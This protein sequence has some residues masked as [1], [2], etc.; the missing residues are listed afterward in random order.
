MS[1]QFQASS[2]QCAKT[3]RE[4]LP[5]ETIYSVLYERDGQWIREDIAADAWTGPSNQAFSFWQT[6]VTDQSKTAKPALNL[7]LVWD[8]FER[9]ESS[10][11]TKQCTFRYVLALL[12]MRRKRLRFEA[13]EN[14]TSGA[15]LL[16]RDTKTKKVHKV[17][18]PQLTEEQMVDAQME[19]ETLLGT[20]I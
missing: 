8:C 17:F 15:W 16:L 7:E 12:L 19:I 18:D 1:Y 11:E 20:S 6:H 4:L 3:G 5:G 9:T 2:R 10:Q 13:I 14:E